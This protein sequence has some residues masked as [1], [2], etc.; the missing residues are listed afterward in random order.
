[1]RIL[2]LVRHY[3]YMR[4]FDSAVLELARRGHDVHVSADKWELL[5]G[6][7]LIRRLAAESGGRLTFGWT[8]GRE[9]GA[10]VEM[11]RRLR[12]A[13]DYLRFVDPLYD[14]TPHLRARAR[15]RAPHILLR[16]QRL[17]GKRRRMPTRSRMKTNSMMSWTRKMNERV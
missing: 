3:T 13:L 10:W 12:L 14:D 8:K 16:L 5:G 1:M 6:E 15:E 17:P 11:A 2:F 9:S 7:Q 4:N